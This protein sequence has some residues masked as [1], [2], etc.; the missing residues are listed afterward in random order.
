MSWLLMR[1]APLLG[2]TVLL[3]AL[4]GGFGGPVA[5]QSPTLALDSSEVYPGQTGIPLELTLS[6]VGSVEGLE[7]GLAPSV[8]T[9]VITDL[10]L[11]D[12]VLN[13]VD[14]EFS[15]IDL[16]ADGQELA[17]EWILDSTV[18]FTS[19]LPPGA[20]QLLGTLLVAIDEDHNSALPAS[21][22]FVDGV[23][24]ASVAN[25]VFASNVE[26]MPQTVA[27][28][29]IGITTN[30]FSFETLPA[31]VGDTEHLV[32]VVVHNDTSVQGFSLAITYDP[33]VLELTSFGIEDTI[34]ELTE[35]A[36][37]VDFDD[38]GTVDIPHGWAA[39]PRG[40]ELAYAMTS[41]AIQGATNNA[42]TST[43][44]RGASA[45]ELLVNLTRGRHEN[46]VFAVI[47][48]DNE[49]AREPTR[50]PMDRIAASIRT[51]REASERFDLSV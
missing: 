48:D 7:I 25:R 43:I 46:A 29:L 51:R 34:T 24:V 50:T 16:A 9:V 22:D 47:D 1:H 23:G 49:F 18:P 21:I 13:G 39:Q 36:V 19:F 12:S 35:A 6:H 3:C 17:I 41:F 28:Q 10:L 8:D 40:L 38:L 4:L 2:V 5:A 45:A 33:T 20:D 27:A 15:S 26:L 14:L 30:L 32:D 44:T 37:V 11:E 42:S 31:S